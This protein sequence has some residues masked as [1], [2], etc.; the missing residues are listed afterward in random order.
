[1]SEPPLPDF[2]ALWDYNNPSDT[3]DR[4]RD[5]LPAARSS[6]DRSYL[7]ELLTQVARSQGLQGRFD[8]AHATLDE[9]A[10][11]LPATPP[12]TQARYLLERGRVFNSSGNGGEARQQ[13]FGAWH[14]ASEYGE[15]AYAVDAA[16]MMG[17]VEKGAAGLDWN[18]A[19]L[20]L[21]GRSQNT[22]AR[23]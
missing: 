13:F 15:D 7:A 12:Q 20:E 5:I 19:A 11:M 10:A 14:L 4:F 6:G 8:E 16:H 17:I 9:V 21:S 2:D 1:M 3:E 23:D 18:L 22:R